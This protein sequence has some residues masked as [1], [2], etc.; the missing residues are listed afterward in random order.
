M[1]YFDDSLKKL[2]RGS[3]IGQTF[4]INTPP[5]LNLQNT[6]KPNHGLY[7]FVFLIFQ[8]IR[9]KPYPRGCTE[10]EE[11]LYDSKK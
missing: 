9:A 3:L 8:T 4:F 5:F 2:Y 1:G 6:I 7:L 11:I 10:K